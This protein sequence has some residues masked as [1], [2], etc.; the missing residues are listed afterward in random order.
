MTAQFNICW[1]SLS[2][3]FFNVNMDSLSPEL[4]RGNNDIGI[5]STL[6]SIAVIGNY[7]TCLASLTISQKGK[8]GHRW[9]NY[10]GDWRA[11]EFLSTAVI[12]PKIWKKDKPLEKYQQGC[13]KI[14]SRK[15]KGKRCKDLDIIVINPR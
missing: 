8:E 15:R 11:F 13:L 10:I 3:C 7:S 14:L 6:W 5:L 1:F 2:M 12:K 4:L 9:G